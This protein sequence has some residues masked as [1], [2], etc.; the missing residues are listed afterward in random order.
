MSRLGSGSS[1]TFE[2][3]FH[4]GG[5]PFLQYPNDASLASTGFWAWGVF[6]RATEGLPAGPKALCD[7]HASRNGWTTSFQSTFSIYARLS[8]VPTRPLLKTATAPCSCGRAASKAQ[9]STGLERWDACTLHT[10]RTYRAR[11]EPAPLRLPVTG[12][13]RSGSNGVGEPFE[14]PHSP[15]R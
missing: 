7:C 8:F 9:V 4:V 15:D 12:D 1:Q 2:S 14:L 5:I 13:Y 11:P 10:P 6:S 3:H